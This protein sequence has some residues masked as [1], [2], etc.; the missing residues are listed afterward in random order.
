M[1]VQSIVQSTSF[2]GSNPKR[3]ARNFNQVINRVLKSA[4]NEEAVPDRM[5]VSTQMRS[6]KE[7]TG[8]I[9]RGK[10]GYSVVMPLGLEN[11]KSEFCANIIRKYNEVVTKGKAYK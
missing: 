1:Q 10:N 3:A 11:L 2:Q 4:F 7:I 8:E 6:G 9:T 5:F